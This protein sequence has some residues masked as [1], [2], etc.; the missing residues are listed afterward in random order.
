MNL[1]DEGDKGYLTLEEMVEMINE[2]KNHKFVSK[3]FF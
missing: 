3:E 2:A 1:F